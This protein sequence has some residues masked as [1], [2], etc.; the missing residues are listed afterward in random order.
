MG[1]RYLTQFEAARLTGVSKDTIIR[2]RRAG[3]LPGARLVEGRWV[4]PASALAAAGLQSPGLAAA[5]G[6]PND[7]SEDID[8]AE[9]AAAEV[10]IAALQD[11]LARQDDE[12][13][14]LRQLLAETVT[15]QGRS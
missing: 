6:V 7:E 9:L 15:K 8:G 13:R 10:K 2:A 12:L 1:E 4:V 5:D 3:R 14:F 11:L